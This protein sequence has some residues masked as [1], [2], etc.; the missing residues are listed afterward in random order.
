MLLC[1]TASIYNSSAEQF[2]ML[3]IKIV[4][5]AAGSQ[6]YNEGKFAEKVNTKYKRKAH[7]YCKER[8]NICSSDK[9][10]FVVL[11]LLL[12]QIKVRLLF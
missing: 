10:L 12:D 3:L 6:C 8:K 9:F 4:N 1:L 2:K 7:S 11:F 5:F